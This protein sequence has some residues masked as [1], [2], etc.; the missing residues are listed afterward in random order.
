MPHYLES[1]FNP[2]KKEGVRNGG[3]SICAG[4]RRGDVKC[5]GVCG[6]APMCPVSQLL[7][8]LRLCSP[9]KGFFTSVQS[10][11]S[12]FLSRWEERARSG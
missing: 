8:S 9:L 1:F 3:M 2:H 11:H 7:M 4:G 10:L 5:W 6:S 12:V